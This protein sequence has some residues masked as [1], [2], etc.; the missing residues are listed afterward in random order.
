[1]C[2]C[3]YL[4][5]IGADAMWSAPRRV[6]G[7]RRLQFQQMSPVPL[8]R[9]PRDAW[10]T[11]TAELPRCALF[12]RRCQTPKV[13][14]PSLGRRFLGHG[15][16][17][18]ATPRTATAWRCPNV[19]S[20]SRARDMW[21]FCSDEAGRCMSLLVQPGGPSSHVGKLAVCF[22][23]PTEALGHWQHCARS[24]ESFGLQPPL[25]A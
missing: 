4:S 6:R 16:R 9:T 12:F 10:R 21:C 25:T 20:V 13:V 1:M 2:V 5:G 24:E 18:V 19:C 14:P 17:W 23:H 3:V 7:G 15:A 22:R 11:T 8:L